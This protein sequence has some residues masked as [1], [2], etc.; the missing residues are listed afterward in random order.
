LE[1]CYSDWIVKL[2]YKQVFICND[3]ERKSLVTT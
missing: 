3:L 2:S 1:S